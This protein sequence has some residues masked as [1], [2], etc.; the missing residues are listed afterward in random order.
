MGKR[1][2]FIG[3]GIITLVFGLIFDLQGQSIVGPESSFM[4]A[5]PDWITYGIEIMIVGVIIIGIG[6]TLQ[7]LKK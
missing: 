4:Y 6:I 1:H 3:I 5:N 7:I 2:S